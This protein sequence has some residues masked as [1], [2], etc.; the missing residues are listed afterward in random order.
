MYKSAKPLRFPRSILAMSVSLLLAVSA[1]A[2]VD[3]H[4]G[5]SIRLGKC[6]A[7]LRRLLPGEDLTEHLYYGWMAEPYHR[8]TL[9]VA[10]K[11]ARTVERD[12]RLREN[13]RGVLSAEQL[14]HLLSW[15]EA[16]LSGDFTPC[17]SDFKPH[18]ITVDW[19]GW[20][21]LVSE[22]SPPSLFTF[23]DRSTFTQTE[24]WFG[25]L[26]LLAGA[27]FRV[28]ANGRAR[29]LTS[30]DQDAIRRHCRL[31]GIG[32][33][34]IARVDRKGNLQ[35]PKENCSSWLYPQT[36]ESLVRPAADRDSCLADGLTCA[37]LDSPIEESWAEMLAR[38][39]LYRGWSG[40]EAVV[41]IG[42]SIPEGIPKFEN[43][44]LKA[45][46]WIQ[47]IDGQ[48]LGIIEGWRDL[49]D[50][51]PSG[52][53]SLLSNPQRML[54]AAH[55]ALDQ[56]RLAEVIDRFRG[57]RSLLVV[58]GFDALESRNTN[59][60]STHAHALFDSLLAQQIGFDLM[61][62]GDRHRSGE[63]TQRLADR[64]PV[65]AFTPSLERLNSGQDSPTL[66]VGG[67]DHPISTS[68]ATAAGTPTDL[69]AEELARILCK[70]AGHP[71]FFAVR[72]EDGRLANGVYC[73]STADGRG[74]AVVNLMGVRRNLIVTRL[75]QSGKDDLKDCMTGSSVKIGKVLP[76]LPYQVRVLL[77]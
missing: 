46:M 27:G 54:C 41:R 32:P 77:P 72:E 73:R 19:R 21:E 43:E 33:L 40:G 44:R 65:V 3:E 7:C 17:F 8:A 48:K 24:R 63:L 60:W 2:D 52:W 15:L 45:A 59:R 26:D 70:G 62:V 53:E 22:G 61:I 28:Y 16:H 42:C 51:S 75:E 57:T 55:T 74:V 64:Y 76:C 50:G 25:D 6:K 14:D 30:D 37:I 31:L 10:M 23:A 58:V 13:G 18:R 35:L 1:S 11:T 20:P 29:G 47:A 67:R 69:L 38:A 9:A 68:A 71:P 39:S 56:L 36:L 4:A 12:L 5:Y 34:R 49:R 66:I